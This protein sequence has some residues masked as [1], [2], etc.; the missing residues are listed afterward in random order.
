MPFHAFLYQSGKL[1]DIGTLD[2]GTFSLGT[3][4]NNAGQVVGYGTALNDIP[5]HAFLYSDG[6]MRDIGTLGGY[7]SFAY[8]ADS[9]EG[10]C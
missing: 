1:V 2:R 4:I 9:G 3:A 8:A 5:F 10:E 6:K 7:N